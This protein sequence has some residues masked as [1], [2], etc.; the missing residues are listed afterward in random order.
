MTLDDVY[1]ICGI[2]TSTLDGIENGKTEPKLRQLVLIAHAYDLTV[3][4]LFELKK[5]IRVLGKPPII[6]SIVL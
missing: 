6:K 5:E 2:P 1:K 3:C 4:D